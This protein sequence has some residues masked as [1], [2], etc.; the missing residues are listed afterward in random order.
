MGSESESIWRRRA[1]WPPPADGGGMI[2]ACEAAHA[3]VAVGDL[4]VER[5]ARARGAAARGADRAAPGSPL[6]GA[7]VARRRAPSASPGRLPAGPGRQLPLAAGAHAA[8]GRAH[9]RVAARFPRDPRAPLGPGPPGGRRPSAR[10]RR[11]PGR[12]PRDRCPRDRRR[13]SPTIADPALRSA[14]RRRLARSAR[15][16]GRDAARVL[17]GS[18]PGRRRCLACASGRAG[19]TTDRAQRP[20]RRRRAVAAPPSQAAEALLL[21]LGRPAPRPGRSVQG[22]DRRHARRRIKRDP[23]LVVPVA[24]A[25]AVAGARGAARSRR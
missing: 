21:L 22:G 19:R 6:A 13:P 25:G 9:R 20:P 4:L 3:R 5:G 24:R 15:P 10:P 12:S 8:L 1:C 18:T 14:A 17:R 16:A 7:D 11:P 23:R 2:A